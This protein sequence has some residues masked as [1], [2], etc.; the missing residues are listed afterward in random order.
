MRPTRRKTAAWSLSPLLNDTGDMA[1]IPTEGIVTDAAHSIKNGV[2]EYQ[3]VDLKT[4]ERLFYRNLG[5]KTVNIGEFL[6]VV[7]AAKHI[8]ENDFQPRIIYTDSVTAITWFQNKHTTSKKKC[9]GLQKAEIFLK[10]L[11]WDVDTIEV[12]HWDNSGWGENPADFG[13]K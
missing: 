4:G 5:N 11:S 2:T 8:I 7:A 10:A 1:H 6:A 9:R 13:N 12:R 3:G